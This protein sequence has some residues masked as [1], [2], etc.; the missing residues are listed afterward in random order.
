MILSP[1]RVR[2]SLLSPISLPSHFSPCPSLCFLSRPCRPNAG[3]FFSF[4][5]LCP[6]NSYLSFL[7][8]H[9]FP[10]LQQPFSSSCVICI[11]FHF[12]FFITYLVVFC[13]LF[14]DHACVV[15]FSLSVRWYF[16]CLT[17]EF[18]NCFFFV[19]LPLTIYHYIIS[20]GIS[21]G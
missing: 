4:V 6:C 13:F 3:I 20:T 1:P 10:L 18:A 14:S 2:F 12:R 21:V 17:H 11:M 5:L 8:T 15:V 16:T 19:F 9:A 7:S